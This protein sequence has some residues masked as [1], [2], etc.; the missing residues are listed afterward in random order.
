M[1]SRI[2]TLEFGLKNCMVF[3][4]SGSAWGPALLSAASPDT[5]EWQAAR[6][7]HIAFDYCSSYLAEWPYDVSNHARCIDMHCRQIAPFTP[8]RGVAV[9]IDLS[10]GL[11]FSRPG[12]SS[13][14]GHLIVETCYLN[15][16]QQGAGH[17]TLLQGLPVYV[18]INSPVLIQP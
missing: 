13:P 9:V 16:R 18:I 6:S 15:F 1:I 12:L 5:R 4:T 2:S 14:G 7:F 8:L 3:Y 11:G 10:S 17:D